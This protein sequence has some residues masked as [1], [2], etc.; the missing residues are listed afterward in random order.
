M[1][2]NKKQAQSDAWG[3][4][5]AQSTN[6]LNRVPDEV[7]RARTLASKKTLGFRLTRYLVWAALIAL[8]LSA[9]VVLGMNNNIGAL[10]AKIDDVPA[11]DSVDSPGKATATAEV[12]KWLAMT[13]PPLMGGRIVSWDGFISIE[14]PAQTT[15]EAKTNPL[16]DYEFEVHTFTLAD[17]NDNLFTSSVQ[18]AVGPDSSGSVI[19]GSPSLLAVPPSADIQVA[20]PWFGFTRSAAGDSVTQ[21]VEAWAT[22][23]TS[24]D[25][26]TL[27]LAVGDSDSNHSFMPLYGVTDVVADVTHASFVPP[28]GEEA[29]KYTAGSPTGTMLAQVDLTI[30]W[31]GAPELEQG[32]RNSTVITYDLLISKA[33]TASP[34]VVAWGAPGT[35]PE[36]EAYGNALIGNDVKGQDKPGATPKPTDAPE[37]EEEE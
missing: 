37:D 26:A 36:L 16:P 20:S 28:T 9:L 3:A 31:N 19:V 15:Q 11:A 5:P 13:P 4:N 35:A 6:T 32:E 30:T 21:S 27:R 29:E 23:F 17:E 22:A 7:P 8:P 33:D 12:E 34:Q 24:G 10:N 1:A 25:P 2:R 14:K 18:V